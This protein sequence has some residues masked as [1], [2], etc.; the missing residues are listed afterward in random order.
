MKRVARLLEEEKPDLILSLFQLSNHIVI[1]TAKKYFPSI[2]TAT[3]VQDLIT[4]HYTWVDPQVDLHIVPTEEARDAS[5]KFGMDEKKIKILGFPMRPSF[6]KPTPSKLELRK[7]WGLSPDLFTIFIM[8]GGV[9]IGK[10]HSVAEVINESDLQNIQLI[11]VA[12]FNKALE[13]KLSSTKF[14]FPIKVFGFTNRVPEI[15]AASDMIVTK[16]GPG[17]IIEAMTKELPMVLNYYMPQEKGNIDYV[18]R[19]GLGYFANK[20]DTILSCIR[21]IRDNEAAIIRANIKKISR[22]HA[23]YDIADAITGLL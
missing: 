23:I 5:I 21:R 16:A 6:L 19:H 17:S 12:G 15:M 20:P 11:V 18:E 3:V 1:D 7:E 4:I 13:A 14:R 10:L 22:P 9:G 8:G 2:P